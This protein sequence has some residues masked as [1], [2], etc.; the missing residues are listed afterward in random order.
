[1][2]VSVCRINRCVVVSLNKFKN[3]LSGGVEI[4]TKM[5]KNDRK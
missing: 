5:H 2:S 1:M 4:V 3:N